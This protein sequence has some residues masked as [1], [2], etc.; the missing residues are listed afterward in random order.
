[1]T[2]KL[3]L[4]AT[5]SLGFHPALAE[6]SLRLELV[7]G[8]RL[9]RKFDTDTE[10]VVPRLLKLPPDDAPFT[11]FLW[12][13]KAWIT[14]NT[15]TV[16]DL[17]EQDAGV[18]GGGSALRAAIEKARPQA[19]LS[20]RAA[21]ILAT[22]RAKPATQAAP[23]AGLRLR[24]LWECLADPQASS[25]L[26]AAFHTMAVMHGLSH[27]VALARV[28]GDVSGCLVTLVPGAGPGCTPTDDHAG[29]CAVGAE[30]STG[31]PLKVEASWSLTEITKPGWS[32]YST[33]L[34]PPLPPRP[35][36]S[37]SA[38]TPPAWLTRRAEICQQAKALGLECVES[39]SVVPVPAS[40]NDN[41]YLVLSGV[42][43]LFLLGGVGKLVA[44]RRRRQ[45]LREKRQADQKGKRF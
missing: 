44:D 35:P 16:A 43:G 8:V 30:P 42:T 19:E 27:E 7:P 5:L 31:N 12:I 37:L 3:V 26:D 2:G 24:P 17:A 45:R 39:P 18:T 32:P 33:P 36:G 23:D 4:L 34:F 28:C 41:M 21:A 1:M 22:V 14:S 9:E 6:V 20:T 40:A 11:E 29:R 38:S 15:W 10:A 25:S 13:P